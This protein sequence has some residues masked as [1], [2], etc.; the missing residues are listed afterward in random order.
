[1]SG[2]DLGHGVEHIFTPRNCVFTEAEVEGDPPG[3]AAG[4]E[5][6]MEDHTLTPLCLFHVR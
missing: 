5:S 3:A 1:M 4:G 2:S 6:S